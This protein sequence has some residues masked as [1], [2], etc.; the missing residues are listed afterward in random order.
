MNRIKYWVVDTKETTITI[1]ADGLESI[2][3]PYDA[4]LF[5]TVL[6]PDEVFEPPPPIRFGIETLGWRV[7]QKELPPSGLNDDTFVSWRDVAAELAAALQ[8]VRQQDDPEDPEPD[9]MASR[10]LDAFTI[11]QTEEAM[12]T[13]AD[14]LPREED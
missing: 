5:T 2:R 6:E 4:I 10:A 7:V 3:F 14:P 8:A 12:R 9:E 11:A 1:G 13:M